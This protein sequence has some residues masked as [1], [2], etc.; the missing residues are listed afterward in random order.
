M[1]RPTTGWKRPR[2]F[3]AGRTARRPVRHLSRPRTPG[4]CRPVPKWRWSAA[5]LAQPRLWRNGRGPSVR[6]PARSKSA[7]N[8]SCRHGRCGSTRRGRTRCRSR[9]KGSP[10]GGRRRADCRRTG[11]FRPQ[12]AACPPPARPPPPQCRGKRPAFAA[13]CRAVP[14]RGLP[15]QRRR[16]AGRGRPPLPARPVRQHRAGDTPA[17]RPDTGPPGAGPGR[18]P[19]GRAKPGARDLLPDIAPCAP[20][21]GRGATCDT[22]ARRRAATRPAAP[23]SAARRPRSPRGPRPPRQAGRPAFRAACRPPRSPSPPARP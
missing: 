20:A 23:P 4:C 13:A 18:V 7:T 5:A 6:N 19:G 16:H 14:W 22:P 8:R 12:D 15:G 2:P 21:R 9:V 10:P 3:L 17:G 1:P 11:R